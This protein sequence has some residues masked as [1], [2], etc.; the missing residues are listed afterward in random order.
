MIKKILLNNGF[1]NI[2]VKTNGNNAIGV[3]TKK[4]RRYQVLPK[5]DT[6]IEVKMQ[7]ILDELN[8]KFITHKYIDI[9][10]G[11]QC[12]IFIPL[13]NLIIECDGD[14]WHKRP[15]GRKIDVIRSNELRVSG[16]KLLRFWESEIKVMDKNDL[17]LK[18]KQI[19]T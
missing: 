18:L 8:I 6:S 19:I 14:Y 2:T 13:L 12:D 16:Y 17:L 4:H 1:N 11:Y 7:S 10:H 15:Y 3:N 9:E 5:K